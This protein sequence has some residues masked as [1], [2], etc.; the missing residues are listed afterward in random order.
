MATLHRGLDAAER[1]GVLD[2]PRRRLDLHG[3]GDVEGEQAAEARVADV[4][5]HPELAQPLREEACRLGLALDADAEGLQAAGDEGGDVGRAVRAG[6]LAE[7]PE[8]VVVRLVAADDRAGEA[9]EWPVR[10]FV[11]ECRPKSAPCSS[12]R[13]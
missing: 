4:L 3:V 12:G 11:A 10:Y 1:G 8:A 5:D 7:L 2:Q 13:R 6:A 9:S